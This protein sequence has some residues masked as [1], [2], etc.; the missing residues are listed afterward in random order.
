MSYPAPFSPPAYFPQRSNPNWN[1]GR[2]TTAA[3]QPQFGIQRNNN[4]AVSA[5][6]DYPIPFQNNIS[7]NVP[8]SPRDTLSASVTESGKH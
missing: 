3:Q 1:D 8:D 6:L 4:L 2:F 7:N 5:P